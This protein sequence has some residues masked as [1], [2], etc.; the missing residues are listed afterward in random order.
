[1][2]LHIAKVRTHVLVDERETEL[3]QLFADFHHRR[4]IPTQAHHITAQTVQL[5]D[6]TLVEGATQHVAL[7]LIDLGVDRFAHRLIIFDDEIE[8]RIQDEILPVLEQQRARFTALPHIGVRRGMAVSC[9]DD[10]TPAGEDMRFDKLQD[11]VFA[12]R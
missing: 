5:L 1:M 11:A 12:N 6:V 2:N 9:S 10:V 3:L 8:Q 4:R 7:Q